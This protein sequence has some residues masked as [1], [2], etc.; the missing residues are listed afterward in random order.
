MRIALPHGEW[1]G[2]VQTAAGARITAPV[3][4]AASDVEATVS[5]P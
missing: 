2:R 4:F 5:F 1:E 3:R